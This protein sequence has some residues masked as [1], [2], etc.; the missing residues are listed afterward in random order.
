MRVLAL[1]WEYPPHMVGGIGKHVADLLPLLA[2]LPMADGP[3]QID[4]VT[5][6]Y[7]GGAPVEQVNDYLTIHRIAMPPVDVLDHYN[8]VIANNAYF[9][10]YAEQLAQQH[11]YA[12][13]HMHEW[14]TGVAGIRLKHRWKTPLLATIH[15]TERGRHQGYLPSQ[16]SQQINQL[17]WEICFEA[18][19]VIVC[20]Q[21]MR[22]EL[23]QYF[24]VPAD[25]IDIIF[26]GVNKPAGEACSVAEL[27]D[28][29][30]RYAPNGERL[31]FFVGRIVHEKG[32]QILIRAMP[33]IL[34]AYPSTR[35]LVAGKNGQ[36]MWPLA[37]ELGVEHSVDF[38]GF[39][40]DR[41]RDCIYRI[42]DA[43][44]FPSLYEP[45]GI[46]A[47]EAMACGCNVIVSHVGGL[48][49]VVEHQRNGL[50]VYPDDPLSIVWATDQL[51]QHPEAAQQWREYAYTV[52]LP[53]FQW[54]RI[55][56]QT[57][58]LYTRLVQAR[59]LIHW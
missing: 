4:L 55:A 35:L 51:F 46:V 45:F 12:L 15:G 28:L 27:S 44:I 29:R 16:T 22:E 13:I 18:W 6:H 33:R 5:P 30:Q 39:I 48:R 3:L 20:S 21:F 50:T 37:Y 23:Q 34:A 8:S 40:S 49:E 9:V 58:Q 2:G 10:D 25:K 47:L 41:D 26:N 14:L 32:L 11:P 56:Q 43:A 57:A 31:L 54:T 42:A 1:S 52:T 59:T 7:G 38:L 17:E 24:T 19:R 36:R 53:Q